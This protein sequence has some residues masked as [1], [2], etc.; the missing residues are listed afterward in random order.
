M[1]E[2]WLE[3]HILKAL[4]LLI[5]SRSEEGNEF[6]PLLHVLKA[7]IYANY[8]VSFECDILSFERDLLVSIKRMSNVT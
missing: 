2:H 4:S 3:T 7:W 8:A 5:F 6:H 1:D